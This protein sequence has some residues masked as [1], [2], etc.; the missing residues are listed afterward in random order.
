MRRRRRDQYVVPSPSRLQ[1]PSLS[2]SPGPAGGSLA[3]ATCPSSA[4]PRGRNTI[5]PSLGLGIFVLLARAISGFFIKHR[6]QPSP[7]RAALVPPARHLLPAP[8]R[9]PCTRPAAVPRSRH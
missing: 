1:T 9:P 7:P 2:T 6:V 5:R 3:P 8:A 4:R